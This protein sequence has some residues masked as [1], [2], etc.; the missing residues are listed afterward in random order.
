MAEREF[1]AL[2]ERIAGKREEFRRVSCINATI[3]LS[4]ISNL[5]DDLCSSCKVCWL[6]FVN[7]IEKSEF[8]VIICSLFLPLLYGV[9][10]IL[11]RMV[12]W[13][14][15]ASLSLRRNASF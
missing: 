1:E 4:K 11:I 9:E 8:P 13:P 12:A 6:S 10:E 14:C 2:K 3:P 15:F 5:S 7:E